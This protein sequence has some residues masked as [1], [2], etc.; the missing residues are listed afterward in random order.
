MRDE[1]LIHLNEEE[2]R[3]KINLETAQ[4]EWSELQRE[5]ARGVVVVVGKD[6]NLVDVALVLN[7]DDATQFEAWAKEEKIHRALDHDAEKWHQQ[8]T[9]FW[10]VVVAPWVLVQE[11]TKH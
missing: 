6:L 4:I 2:M 1:N 9:S 8:Q 3:Q 7:K 5:F 11:I 10:S